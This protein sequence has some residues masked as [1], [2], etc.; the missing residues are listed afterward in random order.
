MSR[1]SCYFEPKAFS[2]ID[3]V[4][5]EVSATRTQQRRRGE[6]RGGS[7]RRGSWVIQRNLYFYPALPYP[8]LPLG[9]EQPLLV[10][11]HWIPSL[12]SQSPWAQDTPQVS[13]GLGQ[14]RLA[15][16]YGW[17]IPHNEAPWQRNEYQAFHRTFPNKQT[18]SKA[19]GESKIKK[20]GKLVS[21][22]SPYHFIKWI[23]LFPWN[24][25]KPAAVNPKNVVVPVESW[26]KKRNKNIWIEKYKINDKWHPHSSSPWVNFRLIPLIVAIN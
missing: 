2:L 23:R 6:W 8:R 17:I 10:R 7:R 14:P 22:R 3:W 21:Q 5:Q 20:N 4:T 19:G 15:F 16:I 26:K 13:W 24:T 12:W 9:P 1:C 11:K 25:T 18:E